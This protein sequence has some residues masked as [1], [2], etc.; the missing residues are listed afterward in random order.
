MI[1]GRG[2]ALGRAFLAL[3]TETKTLTRE[4]IVSVISQA[5]EDRL[6][7]YVSD[8]RRWAGMS[9]V[10]NRV[11]RKI[12]SFTHV[13]D[14]FTVTHCPDLATR[15]K[16]LGI[17]SETVSACE[18]VAESN[19]FTGMSAEWDIFPSVVESA[20][21]ADPVVSEVTVPESQETVAK[22]SKR[23]RSKRAA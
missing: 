14:N 10:A 2:I 20:S 15:N 13:G 16:R 1:D 11:G 4:E 6:S 17:K 9:F 23:K 19:E 3:E 21:A 18:T 7:V 8:L 5:R 22:V 12:V